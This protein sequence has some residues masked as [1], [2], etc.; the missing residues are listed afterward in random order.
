MRRSTSLPTEILRIVINLCYDTS[1]I[2]RCEIFPIWNTCTIKSFIWNIYVYRTCTPWTDL[3]FYYA[4]IVLCC[5]VIRINTDSV[6]SILILI[7]TWALLLGKQMLWALH[8]YLIL[9]ISIH[10][11]VTN[12]VLLHIRSAHLTKLKADGTGQTHGVIHLAGRE[13]KH[14]QKM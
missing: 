6:K 1:K 3:L 14:L 7:T 8:K 12:H 11:H 5:G 4:N 13:H 9:I 10:R 2:I